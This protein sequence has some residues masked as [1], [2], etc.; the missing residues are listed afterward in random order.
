MY[1]KFPGQTAEV[2]NVPQIILLI[3]ILIIIV[4]FIIIAD[5]IITNVIIVIIIITIQE[6]VEHCPSHNLA[7]HCDDYS[8]HKSTILVIIVFVIIYVYIHTYLIT[9]DQKYQKVSNRARWDQKF[10]KYQGVSKRNKMAL[11]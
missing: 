7:Y 6:N 5:V 2:S 10:Q 3:F 8:R 11:G 1:I 9:I 4:I